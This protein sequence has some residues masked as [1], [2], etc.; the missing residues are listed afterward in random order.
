ML[1]GNAVLL[2]VEPSGSP[3]VHYAEVSTSTVKLIRACLV[4]VY[5]EF[6]KVNISCP[7][8]N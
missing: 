6:V 2:N 5:V 7:F 8:L 3:Q 1:N 4:T